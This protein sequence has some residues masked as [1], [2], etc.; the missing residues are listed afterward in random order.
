MLTGLSNAGLRALPLAA[1]EGFDNS[2]QPPLK[3]DIF[4]PFIRTEEGYYHIYN[5][6]KASL[7]TAG[8]LVPSGQRVADATVANAFIKHSHILRLFQDT[9]KIAPGWRSL[10][11]ALFVLGKM[12]RHK[13]STFPIRLKSCRPTR[14][15][16]R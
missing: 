9:T 6:F 3:K 16:L 12:L 8:L 2:L 11:E 10:V 5:F 7:E 14:C 13:D 4:P 15:E 1:A